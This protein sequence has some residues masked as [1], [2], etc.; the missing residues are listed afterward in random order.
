MPGNEIE[1]EYFNLLAVIQ[2]YYNHFT[3][4][5]ENYVSKIYIIFFSSQV[6]RHPD[7][8]RGSAELTEFM[9]A[10]HEKLVIID[11]SLAF[12]GGIDLCYGR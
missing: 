8:F 9:W 6:F 2:L 12:V 5:L 10:H 3:R 7:R 4:N 11:Q 1:C